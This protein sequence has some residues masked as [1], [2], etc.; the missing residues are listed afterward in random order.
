MQKRLQ[1]LLDGTVGPAPWYWKTFAPL[2]AGSATY[3]WRRIGGDYV[4]VLER[5]AMAAPVLAL[6]FYARPIPANPGFVLVWRPERRALRISIFEIAELSALPE[7]AW[8]T[9]QPRGAERRVV[10]R[11]SPVEEIVIPEGLGAGT[12]RHDRYRSHFA[13]DLDE[14]LLLGDGP[15]GS[16]AATSI[17]AWRPGEGQVEVLPQDWFTD[18]DFDL[19]YEWITRVARDPRSG[20]I[21]GDGARIADFVLAEDGRT[22]AQ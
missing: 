13:D 4:V 16:P 3:S 5:T 2:A 7:D 15:S 6:G 19:G 1:R 22:L 10:S 20:R 21:V 8:P 9:E 12:H 17:Y 11:T 18:D 14:V